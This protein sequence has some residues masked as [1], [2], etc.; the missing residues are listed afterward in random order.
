[1]SARSVSFSVMCQLPVTP[2]YASSLDL[3]VQSLFD[4][5]IAYPERVLLVVTVVV[6]LDWLLCRQLVKT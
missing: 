5:S 1:M 3:F 6:T 4:L 2:D